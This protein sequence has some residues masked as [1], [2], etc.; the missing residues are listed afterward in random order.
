MIADLYEQ[1]D[2]LECMGNVR[3]IRSLDR[4][5]ETDLLEKQRQAAAGLRTLAQ[6][7]TRNFIEDQGR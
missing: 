4:P 3:R 5:T 1:A 7:F 2:Q 6:L